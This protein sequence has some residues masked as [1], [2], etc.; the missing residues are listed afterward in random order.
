[1]VFSFTF[2]LISPSIM[3]SVPSMLLQRVY[4]PS[5]FLLHRIPLCKCTIAFLD[6]C[7][8]FLQTY[9]WKWNHWVIWQFVFNFL[10]K[11]HTTFYS[12]HTNLYSHQQCTRVPFSPRHRQHLFVDLLMIAILTGVIKISPRRSPKVKLIKE[13]IDKLHEFV[14]FVC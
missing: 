8:K 5:F 3:L 6:Q 7:F 14:I 1:M 9:S 11:L 10:R 13:N 4:T 12:G 2:W